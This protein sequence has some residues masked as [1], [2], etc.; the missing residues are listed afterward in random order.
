M[1]ANNTYKHHYDKRARNR[2]LRVGDKVLL[3]LP[4]DNNKMMLQWKGPFQV[5]EVIKNLITESRLETS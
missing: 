3:L 1:K 2:V 4:T 5:V